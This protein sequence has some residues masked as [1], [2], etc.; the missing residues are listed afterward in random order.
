MDLNSK[1]LQG[2]S[3]SEIAKWAYQLYIEYGL[4]FEV[5]LN[6]PVLKLMAMEEG[7]EFILTKDELQLLADSFLGKEKRK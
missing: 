5:G 1:L 3:C 4:E 7:P 6:E 2:S